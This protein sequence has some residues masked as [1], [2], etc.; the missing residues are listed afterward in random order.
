MYKKHTIQEL[1]I[2]SC[3]LHISMNLLG[4]IGYVIILNYNYNLL[5]FC[6][7]NDREFPGIS[8]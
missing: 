1:N 4:K 8:P 7:K 2:F 6:F 3:K 5:M